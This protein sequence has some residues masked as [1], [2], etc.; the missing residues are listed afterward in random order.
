MANIDLTY[1]QLANCLKT[2]CK[3]KHKVKCQQQLTFLETIEINNFR[4]FGFWVQKC[5]E[6]IFLYFNI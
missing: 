5:L 3:V 1:S 6:N 4:V 2:N